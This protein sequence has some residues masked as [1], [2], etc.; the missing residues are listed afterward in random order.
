MQL[1][2]GGPRSGLTVA[3]VTALLQANVLEVSGGCYLLSPQLQVVDDIS[4]YFAGGTVTHDT[5]KTVNGAC[6]LELSIALEWGTVLVQP[7]QTLTDPVSG[8]SATFMLGVYCLTTPLEPIGESTATYSVSGYDR[9]YLLNRP[10]GDTYS[11]AGGVDYLAAVRATIAA[12]GLSGVLIDG[13]ASGVVLPVGMTW[14]LNPSSSSPSTWL[15]IVNALLAA[16]GYVSLWCDENGFFRSQPYVKPATQAPTFVFD[17]D[18][19]TNTI[20]DDR[21]LTQDL[22]GAPNK[23]IFVQSNPPSGTTPVEGQGVYTVVN[24]SDG[25]SS[26]AGQGL[27]WAKQVSLNAADQTSLVIQGNAIILADLAATAAIITTTTGPF[28]VAGHLDVYSYSDQE[29]GA[30]GWLVQ[31]TA[32]TVDVLGDD[33]SFTW[34][35]VG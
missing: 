9:L 2:N 16:I 11:V 7:W 35:Q 28:P 12:A 33:T 5:T 29:M 21:S 14:P 6:Q 34:V 26:V 3:Q 19:T 17:A 1:L 24:S 27:V 23:W 32:W 31:A 25:P 8:L 4:D 20:I 13:T 10:V 15:G 18:D 22:W 30:D